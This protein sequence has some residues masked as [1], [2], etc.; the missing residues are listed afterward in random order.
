M[1]RTKAFNPDAALLAAR[2]AFWEF[3]YEALSTTD[4]CGQMNIARQSLYDTFGS[5]RELFLLA[6]TQYRNETFDQARSLL[7][8][9]NSAVAAIDSFL[10]GICASS[11]RQR[12]LGC[13][14]L[15]S[16]S[17]L[18][19]A[20]TQVVALASDNQQR[21]LALLADV[22]RHGRA[23]GELDAN[24]NPADTAQHLLTTYYGTRVMAKID[25]SLRGIDTTINQLLTS[26][27]AP[28]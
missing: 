25:P 18:G 1:A 11:K 3:G 13:L 20:D 12:S 2:D 23:T 24:L 27:K 15:N 5:K 10:R 8:E 28:M 7:V 26:L 22:V 16:V 21:V 17:E 19:P 6:L 9:P 4:L 14:L